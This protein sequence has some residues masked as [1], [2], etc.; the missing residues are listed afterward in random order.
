MKD[1]SV[2]NLEDDDS[3]T[4]GLGE[5]NTI[6]D[7]E[8]GSKRLLQKIIIALKQ[9]PTSNDLEVPGFSLKTIIGKRMTPDKIEETKVKV[10][11]LINNLEKAIIAEQESY[12]ED[13][14]EGMLEKISIVN[15]EFNEPETKWIIDLLV[16]DKAGGKVYLRT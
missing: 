10:H 12:G 14:L 9:E 11:Y 16:F 7:I 5:D 2:I 4:L 8:D 3:I 15:I 1:F 6:S 13:N